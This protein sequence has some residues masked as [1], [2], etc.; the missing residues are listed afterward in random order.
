M[1]D[2]TS[3]R[4][5]GPNAVRRLETRRKLLDAAIACLHELGYHRTTTLLVT[6]RAGVS[7]GSLLH[8]FPSKA[9]LMVAVAEHIAVL[10][11][12]AHAASLKDAPTGPQRMAWLVDILWGQTS[13][14]SGIA[15][16]EIMLGA[17]SDPDLAE[18]L[19]LLN[20]QLDERHRD[21][22]WVLARSLGA[23]DRTQ[24]DAAVQLYSAA[25]RGLALDALFPPAR[26]WIEPAL[27]L[28]K[29]WLVEAVKTDRATM[30]KLTPED[31]PRQPKGA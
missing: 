8:Q 15:R 24:I 9:D 21:A 6:E 31:Q 3:P 1:T 11:G 13:S 5:R 12:E 18:R 10:R 14:P 16:L 27:Q 28:L 4:R 25:L 30:P 19:A 2:Q 26:P 29:T 23:T 17:R 20:A 7:R 22:V